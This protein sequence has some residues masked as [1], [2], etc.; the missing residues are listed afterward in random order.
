MG[1]PDEAKGK[2]IGH[3]AGSA[4]CTAQT[5][6]AASPAFCFSTSSSPNDGFIERSHISQ[7]S[8]HDA[9][10]E[11]EGKQQSFGLRRGSRR[12]VGKRARG[13]FDQSDDRLCRC[14]GAGVAAS[15][16]LPQCLS[17]LLQRW[18]ESPRCDVSTSSTL[19]AL[20]PR[21]PTPCSS[22]SFRSEASVADGRLPW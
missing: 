21:A 6:Q 3:G 12:Q 15:A 10:S 20:W 5:T 22:V 1:E 19:D 17:N 2:P 16:S 7:H 14:R 18:P 4:A 9:D 8:N 13:P 11:G